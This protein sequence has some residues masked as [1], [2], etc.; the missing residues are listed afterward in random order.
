MTA[1]LTTAFIV[2]IIDLVAAVLALDYV[3]LI[4]FLGHAMANGRR[5]SVLHPIDTTCRS[6]TNVLPARG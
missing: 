6:N 2:A 4:L 1:I 3:L 5:T